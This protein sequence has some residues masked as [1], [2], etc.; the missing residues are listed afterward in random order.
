MAQGFQRDESPLW[1]EGWQQ[2]AGGHGGRKPR[3]HI[4]QHK[5]EAVRANREAALN[6][7]SPCQ[8]H[9]PLI[10]ALQ[11]Q[12]KVDLCEFQGSLVYKREFQDSQSYTEKP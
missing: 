11:R 10:S 1:Q 8:T 4:V 6:S 5:H 9:T 2:A 7:Q 3:A 12:R